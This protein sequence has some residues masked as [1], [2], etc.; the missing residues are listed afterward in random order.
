MDV[1]NAVEK[2]VGGR[3][4]IVTGAVALAFYIPPR[5]TAD[6]DIIIASNDFDRVHARLVEIGFETDTRRTKIFEGG[7]VY[8]FRY[9]DEWPIDVIV[10][11]DLRFEE[12]RRRAKKQVRGRGKLQVISERDLVKSKRARHKLRDLADIEDLNRRKG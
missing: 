7:D 6:L 1:V 12:L 9:D 5:Q 8:T 2:A 3:T 10:V 11:D 4:F